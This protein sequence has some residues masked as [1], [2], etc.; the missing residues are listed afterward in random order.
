MIRAAGVGLARK[1]ERGQQRLQGAAQLASRA[2]GTAQVL[3]GEHIHRR[4]RLQRGAVAGAGAGD[5]H[6]VQGGG[7]RF[8]GL[9]GGDRGQGGGQGEGKAGA[10]RGG[11]LAGLEVS[12]YIHLD[13]AIG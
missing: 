6:L 11:H 2:G 9:G 8:E 13:R 3:G 10:G 7:G 4:G 1:V 12:L 5:D